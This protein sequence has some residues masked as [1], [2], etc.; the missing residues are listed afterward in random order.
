MASSAWGGIILTQKHQ[1]TLR[2]NTYIPN[3]LRSSYVSFFLLLFVLGFFSFSLM[4][5]DIV[6]QTPT[7]YECL[8]YH[9]QHRSS[10]SC[11]FFIV[12]VGFVLPLRYTVCICKV[13][14]FITPQWKLNHMC[15]G[16]FIPTKKKKERKAIL[17]LYLSFILLMPCTYIPLSITSWCSKFYRESM[18]KK[19]NKKRKLC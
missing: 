12:V 7:K 1:Y 18:W 2:K 14:Y 16:H 6:W 9:H 19:E 13:V 5:K 17:R 15:L 11:C 10:C 8:F 3:L 4:V